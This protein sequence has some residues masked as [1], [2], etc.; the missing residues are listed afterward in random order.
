M[1]T[2]DV[3]VVVFGVLGLVDDAGDSTVPPLYPRSVWNLCSRAHRDYFAYDPAMV[4]AAFEA[5][6][7][8]VIADYLEYDWGACVDGKNAAAIPPT[9]LVTGNCDYIKDLNGLCEKLVRNWKPAV[10]RTAIITPILPS[11]RAHTNVS[12]LSTLSPRALLSK[13]L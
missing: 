11:S 9:H 3:A 6:I 5:V 8:G 4:A 1:E 12:S 10:S 2:V 7:Y 13:H